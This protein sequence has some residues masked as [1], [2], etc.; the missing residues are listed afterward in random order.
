MATDDLLIKNRIT[1][2]TIENRDYRTDYGKGIS[3]YGKDGHEYATPEAAM[4]A[5]REYHER[6]KNDLSSQD[7]LIKYNNIEKEYFDIIT[8]KIPEID[9]SILPKQ[10][11]ATIAHIQERYEKYIAQLLNE[12]GYGQQDINRGPKR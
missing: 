1:D 6:M 7:Y 11:E 4:Q 12:H 2:K 5:D 9:P 8:P 3:Y 10:I